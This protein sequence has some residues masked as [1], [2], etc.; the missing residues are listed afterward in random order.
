MKPVTLAH[1]I[2]HTELFLNYCSKHISV[3]HCICF[4][5]NKLHSAWDEVTQPTTQLYSDILK[6][7]LGD[8][9]HYRQFPGYVQVRDTSFP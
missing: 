2:L 9:F 3:A 1:F 4:L 8:Q 6:H 5:L 7:V